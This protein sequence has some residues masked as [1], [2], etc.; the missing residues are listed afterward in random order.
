MAIG[1]RIKYFRNLRGM[2]M[3]YL[4]QRAGYPERSADIRISQYES[5]DIN[6]KKDLIE[7]LAAIFDISP[8]ALKNIE[9]D[10]YDG[11]MHT[12]FI[13]EDQYG[14]RVGEIDGELCFR[15]DRSH[16]EYIN[17]FRKLSD[18]NNIRA[19]YEAGEITEEEY[20]QWRYK[21]PES[22]VTK[23]NK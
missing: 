3:K 14:I 19:K 10:S 15:L 7:K 13:I 1:R 11:L 21:Y 22:N 5:E 9:V 17:M 4:G 12:L 18:W 2:T 23:I 8:I 16:P 20:N 6:P